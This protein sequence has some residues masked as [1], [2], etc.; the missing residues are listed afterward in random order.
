MIAALEKFT[1]ETLE[2]GYELLR[3]LCLIPAPSGMEDKRA[4]FVKTW[5]EDNGAE[6]VYIDK[7]KNVIYPVNCE[8][9]DDLTVFCAHTDTVFPMET[10]LEFK[11]DGECFRC[12]GVGDDTSC[13][14]ALMMMVKFIIKNNLQPRGGILFVANSCEEGLGNLKGTR[15]LMKDYA[16]RIGRFYT[17][18]GT[19]FHVVNRCV[20]SHRYLV[21]CKT[22]GGHSFG[23]FGNPNAIAHL[24]RLIADLYT[25]SVPVK[26]NC[27]TTYNVGTIEGGTSV[28]T[29]AQNAK[30]LCEYRSDD[31]ECLAKM[32]A[33]FEEKFAKA[34]AEGEGKAEFTVTLVGERPCGGEID[35]K[36][37]R[38]MTDRAKELSLK[39]SG[40]ECKENSGSTD[41]NIP[42]SLGVP[43]LCISAYAGGGSHT[44]EE[45]VKI[46][47]LEPGRLLVGEIVLDYFNV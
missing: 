18:D 38:Q 10:P 21:E 42:M 47:S 8:G 40:A 23:A 5:L 2:E 39:Y 24:S 7:A 20:G 3:Q 35:E 44:R 17:V 13:L 46:D 1:K 19:N 31:A 45:F 26:E 34:K 22:C 30:M 9:N 33:A 27:K 14:V 11:N 43:A 6:G 36:L 4:E 41:C 29:I 28:N 12:P 37:H 32:Q 15:R 16:G 25:I